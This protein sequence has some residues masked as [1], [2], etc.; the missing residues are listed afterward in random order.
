MPSA[1]RNT[2]AWA[3]VT[4][5]IVRRSVMTVTETVVSPARRNDWSAPV[6]TLVRKVV[7]PKGIVTHTR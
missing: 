7:M 6:A 4:E 2:N 3:K 5:L 1:P